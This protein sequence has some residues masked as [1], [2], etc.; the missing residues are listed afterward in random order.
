MDVEIT[1]ADIL[2]NKGTDVVSI[3][4]DQSVAEALSLMSV[5]G[6]G[7][8][9]AMDEA[10]QIAGILSERDMVRA[11]GRLQSD[12]FTKSVRDLMS[13]PVI[14]CSPHDTVP[15]IMNMM[16]EQRFRHVPVV[17]D[18]K[19]VGLVSIGDVVKSRIEQAQQEVDALRAYIAL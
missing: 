16:T 12:I 15:F 11:L 19:L 4:A 5:R 9:L 14:T 17:D 7:A 18:G 13:S 1:V 8:I 3:G 6:I 10:G 2:K